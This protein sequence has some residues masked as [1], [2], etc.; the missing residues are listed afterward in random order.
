MSEE[1]IQAAQEMAVRFHEC[2]VDKA[3]RPYFLHV[4]RVSA[5]GRNENEQVLGAIHD[6]FE[7]THCTPSLIKMTFG[8]EILQALIAIT[9]EPHEVYRAYIARVNK[10]SLARAVKINDLHDNLGRLG[11][12][13]D[14]KEAGRLATRYRAALTQLG[15]L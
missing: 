3:G 11:M 13:A 1:R 4:L 2:Q 12:L 8:F 10:N 5:A 6:L 15:S 14:Q 9:R 7:D